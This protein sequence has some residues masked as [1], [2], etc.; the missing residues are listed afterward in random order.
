M[1]RPGGLLAL[2]MVLAATPVAVPPAGHPAAAA[3]A[4]DV[5]AGAQEMKID[6]K[7]VGACPAEAV[8]RQLLVPL[9][10]PGQGSGA[11]VSIQDLGAHYRIALP[12]SAMTFDDPGRDCAAR[13]RQA[14]VVVADERRVHPHVLG[15][16]KWTIEKGV[17]FDFA[18]S[19][20]G[21]VWAPGAEFRGA[22]GPGRWSLFG[23]AGARGPVAL[24]LQNNWQAELLRFPLDVGGRNHH[25]PVGAA[26]ALGGRRS[27]ADG[28]R[29]PGP[30]RGR[31]GIRVWR[32]DPGALLDGRCD[33]PGSQA[34]RG[35]RRAQRP[36]AAPALPS[37]TS[38]RWGRSAR[39]RRGGSGCRSTTPS[40]AKPAAH[41]HDHQ[42]SSGRAGARPGAGA[43]RCPLRPGGE[44]RG[45]PWGP[46]RWERRCRGRGRRGLTR[47][48]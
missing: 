25:I 20:S 28:H 9:L 24:S 38:P 42:D 3:A 17:V 46:R 40:T 16:P 5:D 12:D 8:V 10:P 14:A 27:V 43:G 41:E 44:H 31:V 15:P 45:R 34:H 6:L 22:Y 29:D 32:L 30:G 7:F 26:A 35:R 11:A 33:P 37:S 13:A 48:R 39:R 2:A 47:P 18:S 4:A 36:L 23:S 21:A 1:A 19:A